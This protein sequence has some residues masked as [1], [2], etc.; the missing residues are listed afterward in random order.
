MAPLKKKLAGVVPQAGR[1]QSGT[2][3]MKS[4]YRWLAAMVVCCA[5]S[6]Q[7]QAQGTSFSVS[8]LRVDLSA[9]VPAAIV[10][11]TNTSLTALTVQ[12][13]QR[14]WTQIDGRDENGDSRD[15]IVNPA[16]F[17]LAPGIRQVVRVA[18]RGAPA[19]DRE[20]PMRLFFTEIPGP[21]VAATPSAVGFRV[22]LRMDIPLFIAPLEGKPAPET[23]FSLERSADTAR[24]A[25]ANRGNGH[26]RMTDVV[27][28]QAGK[29]LAE[30]P[31]INVLPGAVKMIELP[32]GS[33]PAGASLRIQAGSNAGP[34]DASVEAPR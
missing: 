32:A 11:V 1:A 5:S 16:I 10:E 3:A 33:A 9:S 24:L 29:K 17:T 20:I 18:L 12:V 4:A 21:E 6:A 26:L 27:V 25:V 15:L 2:G 19:R 30:I 14:S 13:Q 7:A 31:V 8:P 28:L 23:T 34:V 22:A